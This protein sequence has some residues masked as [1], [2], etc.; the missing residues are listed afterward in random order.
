MPNYFNQDHVI[1]SIEYIEEILAV[2]NI[3]LELLAKMSALSVETIKQ[4]MTRKRRLTHAYA[5]LI[6]KGID[7]DPLLLLNIDLEHEKMKKK[8]NKT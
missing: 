7:I 1:D 3:D 8:V 2:R 6:G 4:L 5:I